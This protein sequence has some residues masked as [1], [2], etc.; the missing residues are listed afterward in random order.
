MSGFNPNYYN[1]A[2]P[3]GAFTNTGVTPPATS[4]G[5]LPGAQ[6]AEYQKMVDSV[7]GPAQKPNY[8]NAL[9]QFGLSL[10][11]QSGS[12]LEGIG[13]AGQAAMPAMERA[14]A[15]KYADA[16]GRKNSVMQLAIQD[17]AAGRKATAAGAA[18][19]SKADAAISLS[20]RKLQNDLKLHATKNLDKIKAAKLDAKTKTDLATHT[21]NVKGGTKG[22]G[23]A[24]KTLYDK[25]IYSKLMAQPDADPV[26]ALEAATLGNIPSAYKQRALE[27]T[28]MEQELETLDP[29]SP[30]YEK[31]SQVLGEMRN[32]MEK[33]DNVAIT[34]QDGKVRYTKG[35]QGRK[36]IGKGG[37]VW[38][39]PG[40]KMEVIDEAA[41]IVT[42]LSRQGDHLLAVV[43]RNPGWKTSGI[44][45]GAS[46][47]AGFSDFVSDVSSSSDFKEDFGDMDGALD[48]LE[49]LASK[50][51]SLISP[52]L[53]ATFRNASGERQEAASIALSMA[54]KIAKTEGDS[55]V[56]DKDL[57][58][59]ITQLGYDGSD[60]FQNKEKVQRGV[61]TAISNAIG[62]H[63]SRLDAAGAPD[64]YYE[65][66]PTI[67]SAQKFGW[68]QHKIPGGNGTQ[69]KWSSPE[70]PV[71]DPATDKTTPPGVKFLGFE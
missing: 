45:G 26:K 19:D 27:L 38:E 46:V 55:R 8:G 28:S 39:A 59:A 13:K 14:K 31:K 5:A 11:G 51:S 42:E 63:I 56:S 52:E 18:A 40:D 2:L 1:N 50:D 29:K 44:A 9:T 3:E 41:P 22:V 32:A 25:G 69:W 68:T 21:A 23:T 47:V 36:V 16:Q 66:D 62:G 15:R 20:E 24:G 10:M 64:W 54:Y 71:T 58:A 4:G 7:Y 49:Q 53:V 6:I 17:I 37:Q 57:A 48:Q 35:A 70:A 33:N 65:N 67:K 61:E 34:V 30:E 60:W 43:S 12:V